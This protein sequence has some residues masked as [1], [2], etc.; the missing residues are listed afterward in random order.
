MTVMRNLIA[1]AIL[2]VSVMAGP[3][4]SQPMEKS[5]K[6][7]IIQLLANPEKYEGKLVQLTGYVH[8]EFEGN[9]IWLHKDDFQNSIYSNALWIHVTTCVDW[10]GKPMSGYASLMGRFTAKSHGH[11]RL[12]PGVISQVG[13]CFPVPP[14]RVGS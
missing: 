2:L 14:A 13:E 4:Y 7:S 1:I 9:A 6:V 3:S 5:E 12:W 11:G 8:L 10:D